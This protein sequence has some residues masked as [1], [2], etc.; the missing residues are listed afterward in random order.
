MPPK[1]QKKQYESVSQ[2]VSKLAMCDLHPKIYRRN[3]QHDLALLALPLH[4]RPT[5]GKA[6]L[7]FST[8]PAPEI[9]GLRQ[10]SKF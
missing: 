4:V 10:E 5:I 2:Y 7:L 9:L 1:M 6:A 3:L 8:L